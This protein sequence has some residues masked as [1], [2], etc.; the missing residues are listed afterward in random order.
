MGRNMHQTYQIFSQTAAQ[1]NSLKNSYE[2][3]SLV[4]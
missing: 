3:I 2:V 4:H 1:V